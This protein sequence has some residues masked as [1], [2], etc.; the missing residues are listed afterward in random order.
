[1]HDLA[2]A[3]GLTSAVVL[4][5]E[6]GVTHLLRI[7][8]MPGLPFWHGRGASFPPCG[9]GGIVI[10]AHRSEP[11]SL[12]SVPTN[13]GWQSSA[14]VRAQDSGYAIEFG[15]V[16][17]G[18]ASLAVPVRHL[19]AAIGAVAVIGPE[20]N[21]RAQPRINRLTQLAAHAARTVE[22]QEGAH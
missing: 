19:G 8:P 13:D 11:P 15:H 10:A 6:N 20:E 17:R 18:I 4:P 14:I 12:R 3:T 9:A 2:V 5:S 7:E 22:D 21:F 16:I 1:M